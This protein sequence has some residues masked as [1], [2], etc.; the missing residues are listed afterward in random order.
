MQVISSLYNIFKISSHHNQVKLPH[1]FLKKTF[2]FYLSMS[3]DIAMAN[4]IVEVF[5]I[6]LLNF[7]TILVKIWKHFFCS[8]PWSLSSTVSIYKLFI[9]WINGKH[10]SHG[11]KLAIPLTSDTNRHN[12]FQHQYLYFLINELCPCTFSS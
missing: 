1:F 9:F 12:S 3:I 7:N 8:S 11:Q 10:S 4:T 6:I 2:F 5:Y